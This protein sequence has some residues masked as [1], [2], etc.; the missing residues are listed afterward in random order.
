M[1]RLIIVCHRK[2]EGRSKL[3]ADGERGDQDCGTQGNDVPVGRVL[4]VAKVAAWNTRIVRGGVVEA[5]GSD[6]ISVET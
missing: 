3:F 4:R 2:A 5:G 1:S 6:A